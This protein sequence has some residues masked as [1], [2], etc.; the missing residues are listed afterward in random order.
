MNIFK[1]VQ[2]LVLILFPV[3][4]FGM[5]SEPW[6]YDKNGDKVWIEAYSVTDFKTFLAWER[7]LCPIIAEAFADEPVDI[8]NFLINGKQ[9]NKKNVELIE[10][11]LSAEEREELRAK[12]EV[13]C[14]DRKARVEF[15]QRRFSAKLFTDIFELSLNPRK[16]GTSFVILAKN[17]AKQTLG[18]AIFRFLKDDVIALELLGVIPSAQRRGL[19]RLFMRSILE[20]VPGIK[21]I[22]VGTEIWNTKAQAVYKA[23]GFTEDKRCGCYVSFEYEVKS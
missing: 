18:F 2:I 7:Y 20:L 13:S 12:I 21:H 4:L 3:C 9:I 6:V 22:V 1:H 11:A 17:E 14:A 19:S 23:L 5:D 15:V 16:L 10:G 8:A